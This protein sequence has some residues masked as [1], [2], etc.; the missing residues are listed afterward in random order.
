M[1][2]VAL[3]QAHPISL[4]DLRRL[5]TE[6][7]EE[8]ARAVRFE[9]GEN[10]RDER[11]CLRTARSHWVSCGASVLAQI[12]EGPITEI[13]N[14]ISNR[15]MFPT[16]SSFLYYDAGDFIGPH[17][18]VQQCEL[19]ALVALTEDSTLQVYP[20]GCSGDPDEIQAAF[21]S[22]LLEG[23]ESVDLGVARTVVIEGGKLVHARRPGSERAITATFCFL[24][25]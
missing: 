9:G 11:G 20:R 8:F 16:R 7:H 17:Q 13:V 4:A 18:D 2:S 21:L 19:T 3:Y 14:S 15:T 22:G 6:S 1:T 5:Q 10:R 12:H 23:E 25:A 24:S